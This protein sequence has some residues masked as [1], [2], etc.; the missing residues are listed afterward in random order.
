MTFLINSNAQITNPFP[1]EGSG[2]S[3]IIDINKDKIYDL[4]T[5]SKEGSVRVYSLADLK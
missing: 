4:I 3:E 2:F 1:L 5:I